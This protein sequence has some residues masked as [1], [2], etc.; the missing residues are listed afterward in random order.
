MACETELLADLEVPADALSVFAECGVDTVA[1][2]TWPR[3]QIER[4][5]SRAE[6]SWKFDVIWTW[7]SEWRKRNDLSNVI[8]L[9]KEH[10][11]QEEEDK[12]VKSASD[13]QYEYNSSF[14]EID[15]GDFNR[16]DRKSELKV[17]ET[18]L[19]CHG[20][21]AVTT[22]TAEDVELL[23]PDQMN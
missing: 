8:L 22:G 9:E 6:V 4:A 12:K 10:I 7:I 5:L 2:I 19:D 21:F 15:T 3:E 1:L 16:N 17:H 23:S 13:Q 14:Y 11:S 18:E 20:D